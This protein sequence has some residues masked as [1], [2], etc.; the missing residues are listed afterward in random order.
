VDDGFPS[1]IDVRRNNGLSGGH[2]LQD[3][4]R[5][6]FVQ[7]GQNNDVAFSEKIRNVGS[8][9]EEMES[10]GKAEAL[11]LS[12][13]PESFGAFPGQVERRFGQELRGFYEILQSLLLDQASRGEYDGFLLPSERAN[14]GTG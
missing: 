6:A 2:R 12:L 14:A 4:K 7:R 8:V 13:K 3:G 11:D 1:S 10:L 9:T 5:Q